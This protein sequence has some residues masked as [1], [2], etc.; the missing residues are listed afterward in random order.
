MRSRSQEIVMARYRDI[1]D[2]IPGRSP[3]FPSSLLFKR[4]V[5]TI[6]WILFGAVLALITL[7]A[8][9]SHLV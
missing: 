9:V 1:N 5:K 8:F 6:L 2:E 7:G 3:D 4:R